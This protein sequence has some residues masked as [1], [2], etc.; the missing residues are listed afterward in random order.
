[1]FQPLVSKEGGSVAQTLP[2]HPTRDD[3]LTFELRDHIRR[4]RLIL[5][6]ISISVMALHRQNAELDHD[7]ATVL[8]EHACMPLD[9]GIEHLS[10]LLATCACRSRLQEVAA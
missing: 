3:P 8:S 9:D 7:V 2:P 6:V 1:M 4:L 5:P 10:S